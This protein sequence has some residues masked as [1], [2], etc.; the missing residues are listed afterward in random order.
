MN[1]KA[2]ITGDI[3]QSTRLEAVK[4]KMVMENFN[5]QLKA[6]N[7]QFKM[8]SE[9]FRGDGFQCAFNHP[10]H[11]LRVALLQKAFL[12]SLMAKTEIAP[13]F[14]ENT[15]ID[16]RI[17]IGIAT[18]DSFHSSLNFATGD[19]FELSGKL[20]DTLKSKKQTLA[21]HTLDQ[22]NAELSVEFLLLDAIIS[23]TSALQ[24]EVILFKLQG[25]TEIQIAAKLGINQSAVN[26]RSK[27]GD[28]RLIET[29]L[30]RFEKIYADTR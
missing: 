19:A 5:S 1:L 2:I 25:L 13:S 18:A 23:R 16:A 28:W 3:V 24:C 29:V 20:L 27:H 14:L 17:A 10:K 15:L 12:R 30:N 4:R 6:W 7:K 8:K 26:Q 11:A 21:I 22:F 9:I